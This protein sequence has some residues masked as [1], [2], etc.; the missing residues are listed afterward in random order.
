MRPQVT[1]TGWGEFEI[2]I[3]LHFAID[4]GEEPLELCVFFLPFPPFMPFLPS[5][6]PC[7]PPP[8]PCPAAL[9]CAIARRSALN[10]HAASPPPP[11]SL[12]CMRTERTC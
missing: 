4:C 10:M 3:Q 2:V 9:S 5:G 11:L 1:E 6:F 8:F 12:P 7:P